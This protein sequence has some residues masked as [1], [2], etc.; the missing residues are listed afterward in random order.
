[1][2]DEILA[3]NEVRARFTDHHS[4]HALTH[5]NVSHDMFNRWLEEVKADAWEEGANVGWRSSGEGHNGEY[6]GEHLTHDGKASFRDC[7][8]EVAN[9]YEAP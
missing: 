7:C 1:M 2:S 6:T 5:Q 3:T 9:P 4:K 8:P